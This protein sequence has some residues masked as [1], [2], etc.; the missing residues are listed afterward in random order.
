VAAV[1]AVV[2]AVLLVPERP[3]AVV[4]VAAPEQPADSVAALAA[5]AEVVQRQQAHRLELRAR[6]LPAERLRLEVNVAVVAEEPVGLVE[7]VARVVEQVP[8]RLEL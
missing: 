6:R 7:P 2:T 4:A 1:V 3:A 8:R 5:L